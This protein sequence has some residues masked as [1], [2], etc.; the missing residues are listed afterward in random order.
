MA[1]K[2]GKSE[3]V[4]GFDLGVGS[5]GWCVTR[6]FPAPDGPPPSLVDMGVRVFPAGSEGDYR[7]GRE[8]SRATE[9]RLAR[10]MRNQRHERRRRLGQ[11]A[12]ELQ[13]IGLLPLGRTALPAERDLFFKTLDATLRPAAK[14]SRV[15]HQTWLHRLFANGIK[16]ERL[17]PHAL[18]RVLYHA[19]QLRGFQSNARERAKAK[20]DKKAGAVYSGIRGLRAKVESAGETHLVGY[21]AKLDPEADEQRIRGRYT[22]REDRRADVAALF[23]AQRS[24]HPVLAEVERRERLLSLIFQQ[25][26]LQDSSR[27]IG[28]CALDGVTTR[29]E[30]GLPSLQRLRILQRVNDLEVTPPDGERMPRPLTPEERARLRDYLL[31]HDDITFTQLRKLLGFPAKRARP[32]GSEAREPFHEFNFEREDPESRIVGDR[33][34]GAVAP[35]L[36]EAWACRLL[37]E[38]D[39]LVAD[40]LGAE[41]EEAAQ[42]ILVER[43]QLAP[44]QAAALVEVA[45]ETARGRFCAASARLLCERLDTTDTAPVRL[46][47]ALGSLRKDKGLTA[48]ASERGADFLPP[49]LPTHAGVE[50]FC[51]SPHALRN[52]SILRVLRE[53]RLVVNALIRKHG[54]PDRIR[55]EFARE[56]KN[57]ARKRQEIDRKQKARAAERERA[58]K[59]LVEGNHRPSVAAVTSS[60]IEKWLLGEECAWHC[61]YSGEPISPN[62]VFGPGSDVQ[63]EHIIPRA[64][65]LDNSFANKTLAVADWN[66]RKARRSP[67][68]AFSGAADWPDMLVRVSGFVGPGARGKLA[69]FQWDD[70][71]LQRRYGG[72]TAR[73]LQETA[74]AARLAKEYLAVLFG[75]DATDA[76]DATGTRR[77]ETISGVATGLFRQA[78][79]CSEAL[80]HSPTLPKLPPDAAER[81]RTGA[82][83]KLRA[84]HRHHAIDALVVALTSP[85]SVAALSSALAREE[86]LRDF[87]L[88]QPSP[89]FAAQVRSALERIV[90]SH[91]VNRR[92]SGALHKATYYQAPRNDGQRFQRVA[93]EAIKDAEKLDLIVDAR[94][95]SAVLAAWAKRGD[96]RGDPSRWFGASENLPRLPTGATIKR[97]TLP[98]DKKTTVA[99]GPA[100]DPK[101]Q[102][103]VATSGNFCIVVVE[104]PPK[105]AKGKARWEFRPVTLFE[106]ARRIMAGLDSDTGG[107]P[108]SP[109]QMLSGDA[110]LMP[111]EKV[112]CTL[113][114]SEAVRLRKGDRQGI[115]VIGDVGEK[116]IEGA[117][118]NDARGTTV[119]KE[120]GAAERIRLSPSALMEADPDKVTLGPLGEV[121]PSRD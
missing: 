36:G 29:S 86:D 120:L 4:W 18:G 25:R 110:A 119:R 38:K 23:E 94:I 19:A 21:F 52:P 104:S 97:V 117:F 42:R 49:Y 109:A 58:R 53:L 63:V 88:P 99:I 6:Q 80:L 50:S 90:V 68:A 44:E 118:H 20:E 76:V 12:R 121:H 108:V 5:V 27:F 100:D 47:T 98:I 65:S 55:L 34:H 16:G 103:H 15:E 22:A 61:P 95:R 96:F 28:L 30:M 40:W 45:V 56:L 51:D 113:R 91:R 2:S 115:V 9:R 46:A 33:T 77:I 73:H 66:S 112:V 82:A 31:E 111:G 102:L 78:W 41:S 71:E 107:K 48:T 17:A 83:D 105:N 54:K 89:D 87:R 60:D 14:A 24:H 7:S 92:A 35:V 32:K 72:F 10:S 70:V 106:A 79:G 62:R 26:P 13:G 116:G 3:T 37:Q 43:H 101:R 67:H 93:L 1:T 85:G 84:D 69:R 57:P 59:F 114:S 64:L 8:E 11:L 39:A 75:A 81:P 74:W